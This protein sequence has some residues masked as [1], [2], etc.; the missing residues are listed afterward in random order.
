MAPFLLT[1]LADVID[2]TSAKGKSLCD[3]AEAASK[4]FC[5]GLQ[6]YAVRQVVPVLLPL[7]DGK[8]KWQ[9]RTIA[10]QCLEV[11]AVK[12]ASTALELPVI[13]PAIT[14]QLWDL[15]KQVKEAAISCLSALSKIIENKD[16]APIVED[17]CRVL[18]QPK[19]IPEFMHIIAGTVF[20]QTV[21]SPAL[22]FLVPL[23]GRGLK[24]ND[25]S[26]KRAVSTII[27]NMSKLV[28]NPVEAA[29]FLPELLPLM[30]LAAETI[31]D[32]EA[33]SVAEK[34]Q[35]Q[36]ERLDHHC[37]NN[38]STLVDQ[39]I[40]YDILKD[41]A[42]HGDSAK[43]YE[44]K[45]EQQMFKHLAA[46]ASSV[47]D[48]YVYEIATFDAAA[49][50]YI[51]NFG[52]DNK[53]IAR[54]HTAAMKF[55]KPPDVFEDDDDG[56][57][58]LCNCK[59][60][61]AYGTKILLHNTDM[62]LKRGYKYGLLGP[63]DCGKTTLMRSIATGHVEGFPDP[64]V[65]QTLFVEADILGDLSHLNIIDYVNENEEIKALKGMT[66]EKVVTTLAAVGFTATGKARPTDNVSSLS[67]GWRMKLALAR[68]MMVG[69]DIMLFDEPTNHLDVV[70][71]KWVTDYLL[72]LTNV[73]CIMVS[74]H[75][76]FLDDVCSH[77]MAFD[78]LKL[79]ISKG[80]L[81]SYVAKNQEAKAFFELKASKF[82]MKFPQPA[83]IPGVKSKGKALMKLSD[84]TFTYPG[85]DK[86]TLFNVSCQVSLA[87]R[88]ACVGVNGAGKS[89]MIKLL[90]GELIPQSGDQWKHQAAR[91]AYVA[92]H[93]FHHIEQHLDKTPNQYI[94]WRYSGGED[95]EEIRKVTMLATE[96]ELEMRKKVYEFQWKDEDGKVR[97][98]KRI[99]LKLTG[100]RR[101]KSGGKIL[102]YEVQWK[103]KVAGDNEYLPFEKLVR[104]GWEKDCKQIDS[105][106]AAAA[107]KYVRPLTTKNV[108][109]HLEDVGLD[110]EYGTH[111]RIAA[112]SGGQK[113]KVVL[114][115]AMWNQPH[116]LILDEP[117][118]YLDRDSLGA[119]ADAI[120]GFE[121]GVVMITHNDEFCSAL[122]PERWVV[123]YG[124]MNTKADAKRMEELVKNSDEPVDFA[125][126]E[127]T[128]DKFGNVTK[129]EKEKLLSD[130]EKK[131]LE[132]KAK[133][134]KKA[135][136]KAGMTSDDDFSD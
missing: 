61:L 101:E 34:A 73:T 90:M 1:L 15:K 23:L 42:G 132:K 46:V 124:R 84:C 37:K 5:N 86:P 51:E 71:V 12:S 18:T 121:G 117:T 48:G 129:F 122:C 79:K 96:A 45:F 62:C 57:E 94:Q 47:V 28:E 21:Q 103:N 69:A 19:E 97:M 67:G 40:L 58:E 4:K 27:V 76:G 39:D 36:L 87:S 108:E 41:T 2:L 50:P 30:V 64:S 111:H 72:S 29:P 105:K 88:V 126:A 93:A 98:E 10:I 77:I 95:K 119:L 14:P 102:E 59:F 43:E 56:A 60:T 49:K 99:I 107:G 52:T 16:L 70:N 100:T 7:F 136:K 31:A 82:S 115:A 53:A 13:I 123:E 38:P 114:A 35:A 81:S 83:P 75:S 66:R 125:Q 63:N 131:K 80:N 112:L 68:A 22:A 6:P 9:S 133:K 54:M 120:R 113:V 25:T 44:E 11:L 110:R 118:N 92:Q 8:L 78:N 116:L 65:V 134:L 91:V 74:H 127:S 85:N 106:I 32:P 24:V 128:I 20:V 109:Q 135:K 89:T 130:K 55:A 26:V 104:H 17:I 33:R 3:A